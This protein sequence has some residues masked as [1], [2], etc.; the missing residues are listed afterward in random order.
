MSTRGP[1]LKS[2]TRRPGSLVMTPRIVNGA[3]PMAIWSPTSTPSAVSS[4]GR[5]SAPWSCE[6]RVRV[7]LAAVEHRPCRRA[8][9]PAARA[10]SSTIR[11]TACARSA[12][13]TIVG[14]SMRLGPRR[15]AGIREPAVDRLRAPSASTRGW[16]RSSDVGGDQRPRLARRTRRARSGS[17]TAARRS[18]R[19]RPRCRR[20]RTAA[21]ATTRASRAPPCEGRTSSAPRAHALAATTVASCVERRIDVSRRAVAQDQP[22]VGHR[23]Q[24]GVV[25]HEHE[26]R[27]ARVDGCSAAAP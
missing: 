10:R 14:V 1:R 8:E 4:S 17:P 9:T 5:T 22:R 21:A 6:Q 27:A 11:A 24:L 19:R 2:P 13:R 15:R 16:S 18:R 7:G 25:R 20:R 12:G 26:R 23:R 3:W